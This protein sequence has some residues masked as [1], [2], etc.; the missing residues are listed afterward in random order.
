MFLLD[1]ALDLLEQVVLVVAANGRA[2]ARAREHQG[3]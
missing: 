3:H 2:A 1:V